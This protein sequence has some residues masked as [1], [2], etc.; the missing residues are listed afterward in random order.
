ME[1]ERKKENILKAAAFGILIMFPVTYITELMNLLSITFICVFMFS[2]N[3]YLILLNGELN[4]V[5]KT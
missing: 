1:N 4:F 5:Y 3:N 2:I